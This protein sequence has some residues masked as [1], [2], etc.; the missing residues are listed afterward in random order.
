M[1]LKGRPVPDQLRLRANVHPAAAELN[2]NHLHGSVFCQ[3]RSRVI[4]KRVA[5]SQNLCLYKGEA[6]SLFQYDFRRKCSRSLVPAPGC[7]TQK[8]RQM[9]VLTYADQLPLRSLISVIEVHAPYDRLLAAGIRCYLKHFINRSGL[10]QKCIVLGAKSRSE[11]LRMINRHLS[12]NDC[13]RLLLRGIFL[14]PF[15]GFLS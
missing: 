9:A 11:A 15:R 1:R 8:N 14:K 10:L 2:L 5:F 13:L 12:R 4:Q 3:R 7:R 6:C